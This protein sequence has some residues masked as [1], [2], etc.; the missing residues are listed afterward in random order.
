MYERSTTLSRTFLD[1][2]AARRIADAI[3][4]KIEKFRVHM[5]IL[6]T[7]CNPGLRERHWRLIGE[8]NGAP[9]ERGPDTSLADMIDAGLHKIGDQLEEIGTFL[10]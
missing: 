2:P 7:L 1:Y 9:I 6:R 8:A 5:P 4:A 10:S 3:R